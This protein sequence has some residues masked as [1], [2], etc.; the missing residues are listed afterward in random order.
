MKRDDNRQY[1]QPI[2][3]AERKKR[4]EE[5]EKLGKELQET[6]KAWTKATWGVLFSVIIFCIV[7]A[8]IIALL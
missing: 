6:G 7:V 3:D 1:L 8:L 5:L 4:A 2:K